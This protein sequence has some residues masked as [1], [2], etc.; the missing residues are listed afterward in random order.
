M[1]PRGLPEKTLGW[2]VLQWSSEMLAQPNKNMN[3]NVGDPW[4]YSDEQALFVLWF[5]AVDEYGKFL[6]KQAIIERSKGWGKSPLLAGLCCAELLGPVCFDGWDA[7]GQPVG[8]EQESALVQIAA[9]SDSQANNTMDLV[10]PMLTEG[11]AMQYYPALEPYLS[12]VTYRGRKLEKVTASPRGREGNRTTFAVLDETH[13]WVPAEKGP[14]L[15]E[16]I[17]RNLGKMGG[18]YVCTTNA[19][20]PGEESVAEYLYHQFKDAISGEGFDMKTMFDTR[21]VYVEHWM[22]RSRKHLYE[23][24]E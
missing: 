12:K 24:D 9:L 5:Y 18:R 1:L 17:D 3:H 23:G 4:K 7:N 2:Q 19:H 20:A 11:K 14:E 16:A 13:L 22:D 21:E 15:F 8:V 6:Y 10:L